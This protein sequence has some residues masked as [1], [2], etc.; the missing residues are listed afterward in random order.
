LTQSVREA[1]AAAQAAGLD[2]PDSHALL[3][4]LLQRPRSWLIAHDDAQ[5]NA[6]QTTQFA[7]W[8]KR[9]AAGEPV[10]YLLG[11]KEFYGIALEVTPATL[12]PRPDTET[13]VDWALE[14][15]PAQAS[16]LARRTGRRL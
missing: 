16:L 12:V 1:L 8:I 5:L 9:R 11:H 13:L 3:Q 7:T 2:R 10:A 14:L 6:D 4:A 15:L